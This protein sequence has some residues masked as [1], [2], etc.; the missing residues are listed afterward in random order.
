MGIIMDGKKV[1]EKTYE[2][3]EV[4]INKLKENNIIPMLAVVIVGNDEA[5]QVYV[6]NKAK[7]CEKLQIGSKVIECEEN[8][9]EKELEKIIK[10]LNNDQN[11]HGI[12]IQA[13]LPKHLDSLKIFDIVSKEKDVDG[14]NIYNVGALSLNKEGFIPCTVKGI[15]KILE[16]YN[17]NVTSKNI[18]IIGRS[19]IVG[20]PLANYLINHNATVTVCH[21]KTS[22][23][24]DITKQAD[25]LIS[26]TGTA[27]LVKK[28]Y[29][30]KGAVV[31]DV[32]INRNNNKLCGDVNFEEVSEIAS[33]ITPVPGGV[34]PMTIA[35]LMENVLEA[36][37]MQRK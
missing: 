24:S 32:G 19:N 26:A 18:V 7:M 11:I 3:L 25:I 13:P 21:S 37:E 28:D 15:I 10:D 35:M 17:I 4:R 1:A 12:L 16:Y 27:N 14:F 5:S 20:K 36:A 30:K 6:R 23:L 22:N 31:I 2:D 29:V 34:G 9:S 8:I 33:H